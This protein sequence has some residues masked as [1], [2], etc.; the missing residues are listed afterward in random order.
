MP[1]TLKHTNKIWILFL[2][3]CTVLCFLGTAL[4]SRD[5]QFAKVEAQET[6]TT[7]TDLNDA[8]VLS[9]AFTGADFS[10][11]DTANAYNASSNPYAINSVNDLI[12]LAY[13]VNV[14]KDKTFASASYQLTTHLDL[15]G[16]NWAPI[17]GLS[18]GLSSDTIPFC[19]KFNGNGYSVFGLT[20]N[21]YYSTQDSVVVSSSTP[22]E[23]D[24]ILD[25]T[26]A[27]LFGAVSY[28]TF[29]SGGDTVV[30]KPVIKLLGLSN[31]NIHTNAYYVGALA[32][33]VSGDVTDTNIKIA[34]ST[35]M[36]ATASAVVQEC[37]NTGVVHGGMYV[38]GIAGLVT[39]GAVLFNCL[40]AE[41][42]TIEMPEVSYG[43]DNT[44]GK[45]AVYGTSLDSNVG[46]LAGGVAENISGNVIG[47]SINTA[48]VAKF[49]SGSNVGGIVGYFMS[50]KTTYNTNTYYTDVVY[51]TDV[52]KA[53]VARGLNSLTSYISYS[54][55][56]SIKNMGTDQYLP[57]TRGT[58]PDAIWHIGP[59]VNNGVPY[60]TRVN[61]LARVELD[62]SQIEDV[63]PA[64]ANFYGYDTNGVK[65]SGTDW[66]T[67]VVK[68]GNVFYIEQGKSVGIET[69]ILS[70]FATKYE[71]LQWN[72]STLPNNVAQS[73]TKTMTA[74]ILFL[75]SDCVLTAVYDYKCYTITISTN[76][77]KQGSVVSQNSQSSN[78][79]E[80]DWQ[81]IATSTQS[82]VSVRAGDIL[83][84]IAQPS[85]GY[86]LSTVVSNNSGA[87]VFEDNRLDVTVVADDN[88]VFNFVAK[89]YH[90]TLDENLI[91][92]VAFSV[93]GGT[94][95]TS[96]TAN[97]GSVVSI[98]IDE[99]TIPANYF[100]SYFVISADGMEPQSLGEGV[101]TFVVQDFDN[102]VV[103]AVFRKQTYTVTI[104]QS[105]DK[106]VVSFLQPN[107]TAVQYDVEFD[108]EFTVKVDHLAVG[109]EFLGWD[110]NYNGDDTETW[111][112][113][114]TTLS[115]S[116]LSGNVVLTP[117]VVIMT[118]DVDIVANENGEVDNNGGQN[119]S[120]GTSI[121]VRAT[122]NAGF[123]FVAWTDATNNQLSTKRS[124]TFTV[125]QN[126]TI[127]ASFEMCVYTVLFDCFG[128][129][130]STFG[131]SCVSLLDL[132]TTYTYGD[133]VNF[134]INCPVG[135][136]FDRWELN[137][138]LTD[139]TFTLNSDGTGFVENID[140]DISISAYLKLNTYKITFGINDP[141][142]GD[143]RFNQNGWT[144]FS[145]TFAST[146]YSYAYKEVLQVIVLSQ[147]ATLYPDI[148]RN[149]TFSYWKINNQPYD[150]GTTLNISVSQ[151]MNIV[152]VYRPVDYK[153]TLTKSID[154]GATINGLSNDYYTYGSVISLSADVHSGYEFNGWY[155]YDPI[156]RDYKL[157]SKETT[158]NLNID[159]SK[160]ILCSLSKLGT[161]VASVNDNSAGEILGTGNYKLGTLVTLNARANDGFVFSCWKQGDTVVSE[162]SAMAVTVTSEVQN[163]Q[164]V[165]SPQFK[166]E[167]VPND[168]RFG[169]VNINGG[170]KSGDVVELVAVANNNCSF[171]GWAYNNEIISTDEVYN[172]NLS[173][174]IAL[175]AVFQR[176]FNWGIVII[177]AG[178]VL[179]AIL[180]IVIAIQYVK[181]KEAEPLKTRFILDN[182]DDKD[183]LSHKKDKKNKKDI[184]GVPVRKVNPGDIEPVPVRKS[185]T[186]SKSYKKDDTKDETP[187]Q[188]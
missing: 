75:S 133:T 22:S 118:F 132:D 140:Q 155:L 29:E 170:K 169:T 162:Q 62:V 108:A 166:I 168:Q 68:S 187:T 76:D 160:T 100:L 158:Y 129:D 51:T 97:Y 9:S 107:T 105:T 10:T 67:P 145:N 77:T 146:E 50:S 74:D 156:S 37:Y 20:I 182:M 161:I 110:V 64:T 36:D 151:D 27:G 73:N 103:S 57:Y 15:S 188:D 52:N 55:S 179:F 46:G 154:D 99:T 49:G 40:N 35:V 131:S 115:K 21:R 44:L 61:I 163:Y 172:L 11:I 150:V 186:P 24:V 89:E 178:C 136:S 126:T 6:T 8:G 106:Y 143:F 70:E 183:L 56:L 111:V 34:G 58:D 31:T 96:G 66:Y 157:L 38:G 113:T 16:Y 78:A 125:Q 104:V 63:V 142:F 33:Y 28:F 130:G 147:D 2:T 4:L 98:S 181:A 48:S 12:R 159:S 175:E 138:S 39:N 3:L 176:N 173:G 25:N 5:G 19:G 43:E 83:R 101:N 184:T 82:N 17:G 109:F 93:D 148:A 164:A 42:S 139:G 30:A 134:A 137:T 90:L 152:A 124:Y 165:F 80:I 81:N 144:Y 167:V 141:R 79:D 102:Y 92:D 127:Y 149:Y 7:L 87:L 85:A 13:Y 18:T 119:I 14:R 114:N 135:Y 122:P 91:A 117:K 71:F 180:M 94:A 54:S 45:I 88:I 128:D 177:I 26:T 23:D 116:G 84:L 59:A 65:Q 121:T 123:K 185:Y 1:K 41:S 120:Y 72:V 112:T 69:S 60:L 171:V 153:I 174:D 53:G 32:G 95:S 86:K 47:N